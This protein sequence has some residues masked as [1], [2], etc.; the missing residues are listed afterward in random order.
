MV[1]VHLFPSGLRF[2]YFHP[3][4]DLSIPVTT[5][6]EKLDSLKLAALVGVPR[7]RRRWRKSVRLFQPDLMPLMVAAF[8]RIVSGYFLEDLYARQPWQPFLRCP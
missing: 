5:D 7:K 1:R 4:C 8:Q 2:P 3:S 6:V